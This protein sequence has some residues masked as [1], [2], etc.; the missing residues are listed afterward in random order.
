MRSPV[1]LQDHQENFREK[2]IH[3]FTIYREQKEVPVSD[4]TIPK[5]VFLCEKIGKTAENKLA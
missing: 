2:W 5:R 4:R 1:L 3:C